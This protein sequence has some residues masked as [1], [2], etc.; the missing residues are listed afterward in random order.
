M[1]FRGGLALLALLALLVAPAASAQIIGDSTGFALD[2]RVARHERYSLEVSFPSAPSSR[3]VVGPATQPILANIDPASIP[4]HTIVVFRDG[5]VLVGGGAPGGTHVMGAPLSGPPHLTPSF[6]PVENA[7]FTPYFAGT[8]IP[9]WGDCDGDGDLDLPMFENQGNGTFAEMPGFRELLREGNYHGSAWSDYDGDGDP[10]LVMLSYAHIPTNTLLLRNDGGGTFV[11]VAPGQAMNEV[12]D[13]E[14]AVW[15]DFD[16]DGDAD[17]FAPYY[18]HESP[19]HSFLYRN[20]GNGVFHDVSDEAGVSLRGVPESLKPEGAVA[21]DWD[22]DG[23]LDLYCASHFFVNDGTGHF[24]DMR[25]AVGLPEGFDEGATLVDYDNDGDFDF[26]VRNP[27]TGRLFRNDGGHYTEVTEAAGIEPALFFWGDNFVDVDNDGD[28]DMLYYERNAPA[29]LMLNRGDGTFQRDLD[30][31]SLNVRNGTSAWADYDGDG[32]LDFVDGA[33]PFAL[34]ANH[35][36]SQPGFVESYLRVIVVDADSLLDQHSAT[37]RLRSPNGSTGIVQTRAVGVGASYLGQNEYAVHFG[38]GISGVVTRSPDAAIYSPGSLVQLTATPAPGYHFTGWGGAIT[39]AQNPVTVEMNAD[40]TV[41]AYFELD[42]FPLVTSAPEGGAIARSPDQATYPVGSRV[43]LTA[44]PAMGFSFVGWS[45]DASGSANPITIEIGGLKSVTALFSLESYFLNPVALGDG[46]VAKNPDQASYAYGTPV[47]LTATPYLGRHFTRWGVD[48][49]GTA[50]PLTMTVRANTTLSALFEINRY[51]LNVA[52]VGGGTVVRTPDQPTY[53]HGALVELDAF[54]AEGYRFSGWAGAVTGSEEGATVVMDSTKSVTA[55]FQPVTRRTWVGAAGGGDGSKWSDRFNWS[56]STVP[57]AADEVVLDHSTVTASYTVTLPSNN[58]ST[59]V[60]RLTI[61]PSP[62]GPIELDLPSSNRAA[63]GLKVGDG[64]LGV[65]DIRLGSGATLRNASGATSGT[66]V[67][68]LSATLDSLSIENGAQYVHATR[69]GAGALV[70]VLSRVPGTEGGEFHYIVPGNNNFAVDASGVTYGALSLERTSG[71][72]TYTVTGASPL[73]VRGDLAIGSGVTLS[74][75]MTGDLVLQGHL[76]NDGTNLTTPASQ[77]VVF[78]GSGIQRLSSSQSIQFQGPSWIAAGAT[79]AIATSGFSNNGAMTIDGGLRLE[80]SSAPGGSGSYTYHPQTGTLVFAHPSGSFGVSGTTYWPAVS[81]PPNVKVAAAGGITMN[82]SRAVT[83]EFSTSGPVS[84]ANRLTL[85]GVARLASGGSM[86]QSPLYGAGAT[87]VYERGGT[88]GPEWV[89]GDSTGPGVP[90]HVTIDADTGVVT[91]GAGRVVPGNL[92]VTA[93]SMELNGSSSGLV[94]LGDLAVTGALRANGATL[95][96]AGG[97]TQRVTGL[98]ALDLATLAMQKPGGSVRLERDLACVGGPTRGALQLDGTADVLELNGHRL[99][100]AGAITGTGAGGALRGST[101]SR[102]SLTGSGDVGTLRFASGGERLQD[103]D[104]DL[105]AAGRVLLATRLSVDGTLT[106]TRGRIDLAADTL[107]VSPGGAVDRDS[108]YV[109]GALRKSVT[110]AAPSATFEIG[111]TDAYSP[112]AITFEG[113]TTAG[114]LAASA[115]RGNHV[116]LASA[117]FS[118]GVAHRY[119]TLGS[120]GLAYQRYHAAFDFVLGDLDAGIDTT[121]LAARRFASG[122]WFYLETPARGATHVEALGSAFGDFAIGQVAART[123]TTA[124]V[125]HGAVNRL[126]DHLTYDDGATV[127][128]IAA[129]EPGYQLQV[130]SGDASGADSAVAVVM[131]ANRSVVGTFVDR[132][133]TVKVLAP[134]GG[135]LLFLGMVTT[136]TWQALDL[137]GIAS[138]DLLLSRNGAAGPFDS[139]AVAV[140]NA[141][142]F[143]WSVS[144]PATQ[145]GFLKVVAHDV[146]GS[147]AA[148]ASDASFAIGGALAAPE[149]VLPRELALAAP[150]PNPV[151]AGARLAYAIARDGPARLSVVDVQGRELAVLA[152]GAHARGLYEV[153]WPLSLGGRPVEAGLY[154][155]R[156]RSAGEERVRRVI[157]TP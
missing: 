51:S 68:L 24:T 97:A 82:V 90:R 44:V 27:D 131:T 102:L 43:A 13:G 144:P 39:G 10:D 106:L 38:L 30:F 83:G 32:D 95:R 5:R 31:E 62:G 143:A 136:L 61:T 88:T 46:S 126:P 156:L 78:S 124:S 49:S 23:D 116:A 15:G 42:A 57:T 70:T 142:T 19:F 52:L 84:R 55:V 118:G 86:L 113:L 35:L 33:S 155:V 93:G 53:P 29:R 71:S 92:T 134:N 63:V 153:A 16:N 129:P 60:A 34:F 150:C 74:S 17:L 130:W 14:T 135:E 96:L 123:L 105:A 138:V 145:S 114:S 18:A 140:P 36:E 41:S 98:G 121:R 6:G 66:P 25:A 115:T 120:Q 147:W 137:A 7:G 87:L 100:I 141:G 94:V 67:S 108:G 73:T 112:V 69:Q 58:A 91:P 151:R 101:G 149:V 54:A 81:A 77:R 139:I 110:A 103:L 76:V 109:V 148:D 75:S 4:N 119:W 99:V 48:T 89:A 8:V 26:Y 157:V 50:N 21:V 154:F 132:P 3:V 128:V 59:A 47:T 65:P 12:G 9:A 20:D 133:P 45:G 79:L 152:A 122:A 104:V 2:V 40:R 111:T 72:G 117:P 64:A 125:G 127:S 37:V 22:D 28:L 80:T 85:S 1:P 107:V 56:G 146:A 11:D